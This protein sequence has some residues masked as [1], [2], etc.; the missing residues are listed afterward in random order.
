[1]GQC[2]I[3]EPHRLGKGPFLE[4]EVWVHSR[5][6]RG[7]I[8]GGKQEHDVVNSVVDG[9]LVQLMKDRMGRSLEEGYWS[10]G[11]VIWEREDSNYTKAES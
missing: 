9:A 6:H 7:A 8:D 5:R 3:H 11:P 2:S 1:M 4:Y 10:G